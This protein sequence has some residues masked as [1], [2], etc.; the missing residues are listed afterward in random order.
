MFAICVH[1]KLFSYKFIILDLD[2]GKLFNG[3]GVGDPF[4]PRCHK[5]KNVTTS[6]VVNSGAIEG[7]VMMIPV[8]GCQEL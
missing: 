5:G 7:A 3:S 8:T 6:V 4:G 1:W 2:D